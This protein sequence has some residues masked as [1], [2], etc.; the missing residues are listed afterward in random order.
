MTK[1]AM[2]AHKRQMKAKSINAL[3]RRATLNGY[4]IKG[5]VECPVCK[6]EMEQAAQSVGYTDTTPAWAKATCAFKFYKKDE[7]LT[8]ACPCGYRHKINTTYKP[9]IKIKC[10]GK[11]CE[12]KATLGKREINDN[13]GFCYKCRPFKEASIPTNTNTK[14]CNRKG[15]NNQVPVGRTAVCY[16]CQPAAKEVVM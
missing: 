14:V 2:N 16:T 4:S 9:I 8:I 15:C 13:G 10:K 3:K 6:E 12:G 7:P 5:M 1:L 11:I